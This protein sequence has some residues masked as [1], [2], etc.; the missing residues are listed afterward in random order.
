[1]FQQL[2]VYPQPRP[3]AR[4]QELRDMASPDHRHIGRRN[5]RSCIAKHTVPQAAMRRSV[6][7]PTR[8]ARHPRWGTQAR[9]CPYRQSLRTAGSPGSWRCRPAPHVCRS[10]TDRVAMPS[11][12]VFADNGG[13]SLLGHE[14]CCGMHNSTCRRRPV[15]V[16]I[17]NASDPPL[18]CLPRCEMS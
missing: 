5:D 17:L 13:Q 12:N 14:A 7:A 1:M 4:V 8:R 9:L 18:V 16:A 3:D 2:P 10:S 15:S 6:P 11:V